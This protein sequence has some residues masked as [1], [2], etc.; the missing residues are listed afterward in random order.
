MAKDPYAEAAY[1]AEK[2]LRERNIASLPVDPMAIAKV[3]GIEVMAKP[4][5]AAGVSGMLLKVGDR[6]GI[7]YATH[8]DN[9]GFQ[10]FSVSHELGH[11]FLP[12]HVDAV[13][14]ADNRHESCA[15]FASK[16][17]YER[18]ADHFAAALLMPK[19][20]FTDAMRRAGDGLAAIEKLR[21]QCDTS[22]I[23][24]AIRY[25]QC[26]KDPM[27]VV[28]STGNQINYCVMSDSLK[29]VRGLDWI[30][31]SEAVP[32]GTVTHTFNQDVD[33]VRR[34]E[35][36]NGRSNMQDWFYGGPRVD[37]CEEVIGLGNY[38]K[39]LTVLWDIALPED[40]DDEAD[41]EASLIESWTPR[42]KR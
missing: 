9:S 1:H 31:K 2:V 40:A 17:R 38:G 25:M 15:G 3:A 30:R 10:R 36:D 7:T 19:Q 12:G 28:L 8:I 24:T 42:F 11:Y 34:G 16:D 18:E 13:L 14:G 23:A 32:N 37:I 5:S 20:P 33:R 4:A 41:D 39:T 35:R 29:D 27:A 21:E 26:C 6:F 22:L